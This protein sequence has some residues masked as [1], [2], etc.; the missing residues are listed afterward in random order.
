MQKSPHTFSIDEICSIGI[1]LE[2]TG[3]DYYTRMANRFPGEDFKK[4]FLKL[5]KMEEKH[6]QELQKIKKR[7]TGTTEC[8]IDREST[9]YIKALLSENVYMDKIHLQMF[10]DKIKDIVDVL[11][12]AIDM[13]KET[14]LFYL[15]LNV[16]LDGIIT[17]E[18]HQ[19]IKDV[20]SEER[21]HLKE[22][23]LLKAEYTGKKEGKE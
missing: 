11:N 7:R 12:L 22:L 3:I 8:L 2:R 1:Q 21:E 19:I 10:E 20:T 9:A 18:E 16:G 13:E 23:A 14:I 15:G 17:H 6:E 4:I 5:I